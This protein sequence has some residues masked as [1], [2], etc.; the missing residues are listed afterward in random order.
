MKIKIFVL[1][2]L[3]LCIGVFSCTPEVEDE[4]TSTTL[5][6]GNDSGL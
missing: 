2:I 4:E 3:S 1:V 5:C 6:C